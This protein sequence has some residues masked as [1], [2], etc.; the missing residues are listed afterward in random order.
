MACDKYQSYNKR[1]NAWVKYKKKDNGKTKILN[2]KQK[3]PSK[4]F[5]GIEKK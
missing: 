3:E 1:S 5:K 2:T 4:P